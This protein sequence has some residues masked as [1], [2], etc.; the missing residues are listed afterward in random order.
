MVPLT[1]TR[2]ASGDG[3]TGESDQQHGADS[4]QGRTLVPVQG[5]AMPRPSK[6]I[7]PAATRVMVGSV[8]RQEARAH[9]VHT[10]GGAAK[11]PAAK[12]IGSSSGCSNKAAGSTLITGAKAN[13]TATPTTKPVYGRVDL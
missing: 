12:T 3:Q 5:G 9:T 10:V 4:G 13:A 6:V 1:P 11:A 2:H 8:R 7:A